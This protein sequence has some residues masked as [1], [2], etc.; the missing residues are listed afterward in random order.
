MAQRRRLPVRGDDHDR[1]RLRQRPR[2][3]V[4]LGHPVGHLE[5]H[6][7]A[8]AEVQARQR[9]VLRRPGPVLRR[10]RRARRRCAAKG[11]RG[12][13]QRVGGRGRARSFELG[14]RIS[15]S[16]SGCGPRTLMMPNSFESSSIPCL[17]EPVGRPAGRRRRS[18]GRGHRARSEL[19]FFA[20]VV[21]LF[22]PVRVGGLDGAVPGE[23]RPPRA[24]PRERAAL[25]AAIARA[26]W[27]PGHDEVDGTTR[28]LVRR[29]Y[30]GLDGQPVVLEERVME[31]FRGDDPAWEAR[32]PR[33]CRRRGSAAAT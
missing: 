1:P 2:P 9:P 21:G 26:R 5:Q 10:P 29:A 28:V 4:Q 33:R 22:L 23:R 24:P 13:D 20:L 32:L 30:T 18:V 27:V 11:C 16:W 15:S 8:V 25:A 7:R 31:T 3:G 19:L 14:H 12:R 6:R 17:A